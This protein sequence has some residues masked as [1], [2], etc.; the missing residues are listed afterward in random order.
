MDNMIQI[1]VVTNVIERVLQHMC[2]CMEMHQ[3]H[4]VQIKR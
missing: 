2:S 3:S 4:G 1:G